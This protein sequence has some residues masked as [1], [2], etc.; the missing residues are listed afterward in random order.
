MGLASHINVWNVCLLI[1]RDRGYQLR[2][3]GEPNADGSIPAKCHWIAENDGF[4]FCGDNPIEL[5]GLTA[6][7]DFKMPEKDESYW[8]RIE[9]DDILDELYEKAFPGRPQQSVA[10]TKSWRITRRL[11][12][13]GRREF[14]ERWGGS[15]FLVRV[16]REL[17][18]NDPLLVPW[19]RYPAIARGLNWNMG[20]GE[21]YMRVWQYWVSSLSDADFLEYLRPFAPIPN[22][23]ADWVAAYAFADYDNQQQGEFIRRLA[24]EG[25][26]DSRQWEDWE[27][28]EMQKFADQC[29]RDGI[30]LET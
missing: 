7:H 19:K 17:S 23:W 24:N 13:N 8:W 3:S 15:D 29:R 4:Y 20:P 2:V 25:L 9:G 18:Q 16:N 11:D 6:V 21:D 5:L 10:S 27:S 22:D 30:D 12:D 14:V 28:R 26:I 1:L